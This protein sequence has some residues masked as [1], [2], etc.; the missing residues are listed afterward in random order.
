MIAD[1]GNA[2]VLGENFRELAAVGFSGGSAN[3]RLRSVARGPKRWY[4][5][6]TRPRVLA[7]SR[8]HT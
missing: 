6:V 3:G 1:P 7:S 2:K 5:A 8:Q 4:I